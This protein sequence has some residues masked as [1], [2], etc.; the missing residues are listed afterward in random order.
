MNNKTNIITKKIGIL[1]RILR[2]IIGKTPNCIDCIYC[3]LDNN[4]DFRCLHPFINYELCEVAR[5]WYC[6]PSGVYFTQRS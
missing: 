6:K 4:N 3:E 1:E 5:F 2:R